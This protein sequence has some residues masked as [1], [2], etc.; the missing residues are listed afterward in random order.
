MEVH[1]F[2]WYPTFLRSLVISSA[3][4]WN[5]LNYCCLPRRSVLIK[6][7]VCH[8]SHAWSQTGNRIWI[9][10]RPRLRL[11]PW[12]R[13]S[14][15]ISLFLLMLAPAFF[16]WLSWMLAHVSPNKDP[17]MAHCVALSPSL[18]VFLYRYV[19]RT[20]LLLSSDWRTPWLY[21]KQVTSWC[22]SVVFKCF[23]IGSGC[24][25]SVSSV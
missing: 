21:S 8:I 4:S 14:A 11:N 10:Q 17:A 16:T 13:P 1:F 15:P 25:V 7:T 20:R 12:P 9:S 2:N 24:C 19:Q 23:I 3:L 6:G 18:F 22:F 5:A